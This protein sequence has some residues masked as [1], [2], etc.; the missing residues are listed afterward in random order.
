PVRVVFTDP[1]QLDKHP[2]RI[3]MSLDVEVNLHD[4]NGPMLAQQP[5]AQP[6]FSTGV[7]EQQAAK[8]DALIAAIIHANM[9]GDSK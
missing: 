8:A 6:A 7:Y 5:P 9:A 4:Q 2:L 1:A 3:G